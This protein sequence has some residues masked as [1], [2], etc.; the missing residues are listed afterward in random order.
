MA[1]EENEKNSW[2][3]SKQQEIQVMKNELKNDEEQVR[4]RGFMLS[5]AMQMSGGKMR[6][7]ERLRVPK[8]ENIIKC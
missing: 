7:N 2:A 8:E 5:A 4:W 1:T 6:Q 3:E